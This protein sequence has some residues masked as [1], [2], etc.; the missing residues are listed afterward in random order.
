MKEIVKEVGLCFLLVLWLWPLLYLIVAAGWYI[1]TG[2]NILPDDTGRGV[3]GI[4]W[5]VLPM[6]LMAV[7]Q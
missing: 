7:F 1:A 6:I 3:M 5:V 4:I 2:G